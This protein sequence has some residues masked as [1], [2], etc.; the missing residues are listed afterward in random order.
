MSLKAI[1][2]FPL[3]LLAINVFVLPIAFA[4]LMHFAAGRVDADT[5]VLT[6][7]MARQAGG[8]G[9]V[10]LHRRAVGG[11]RH[12]DRGDDRALHDDLQRPRDAGAAALEGARAVDA[13][14]PLRPAALGIRRGAIVLLMMLGYGYYR[15][16]GEAYALV[17]IGLVSFA[18]V[19]QFAPAMLGGMYWKRGTRAARSP[20]CRRLRGLGLHAAAAVVREVGLAADRLHRAGAVGHRAA[21]AASAVRHGG[22]G[23]RSATRCSGACCSNR[24]RLRRRVAARPRKAIREHAQALLFVDVFKVAGRGRACGAAARR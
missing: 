14:R 7:P 6:L 8:A 16:A 1:W 9:A 20:G 10:R 2:L 19:A 5:F 15:A 13:R 24:R 12:G 22:A 17:S 23:R 21:E 11:H 3:Y 18:A 4:G